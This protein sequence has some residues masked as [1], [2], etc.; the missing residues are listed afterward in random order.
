MGTLLSRPDLLELYVNLAI[1]YKLPI[2]FTR[3][4]TDARMEA[5]YPALRGRGQQLVDALDRHQLP[6]LASVVMFYQDGDHDMRKRHYLDAFGKLP[7]GVSEVIVHCGV[8]NAELS[9]ITSSAT[10][11]DSDRR[12]VTDPEVRAELDRLG[13]SLTTWRE[14]QASTSH[15]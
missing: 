1:E 6:V 14:F 12:F 8:D 10:L 13:I 4:A 9:A 3:Q 7:E 5:A 11:R 15:K 2:M